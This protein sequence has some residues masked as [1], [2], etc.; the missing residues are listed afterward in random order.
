MRAITY[1]RHGGPD[2]M[3]V[4]E[5]PKPTPGPYEALIQV[6]AVSLNGFDPMML[7]GS[8]ELK[9]PMPMIPGGDLAGDIVALGERAHKPDPNGMPQL[10]LFDVARWKVGERVAPFPFVPGEGM[11]GETRRGACCEY[12]CFPVANLLP[13]PDELTYAQAAALPIAYGTA[14]RM[15]KTVGKVRARE[16]VLIL[17]ATGGVG[18]C[19][20]QLA[21]AAG[22]R[23]IAAGRGAERVAKLAKLGAD[24]VIDTNAQDLIQ[25]CHE[26]AGKPHMMSAKTGVDVVINYIGGDTWN[27]CL[28]VIKSNGRML[29]CGATAGHQATT[30]LRYLWTYEQKLMGSNG[31]FPPDQLELMG[32]VARGA[33]E[34]IIH[35][36]YALEDTPKAFKELMDRKA[37]GKIV[38]TP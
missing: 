38:I 3:S 16:T 18:T 17:G 29:T 36:E 2:V 19:A 5:L 34:P 28:K 33:L 13:V 21:K 37:F 22:A 12:I 25:T 10:A 15:L 11:T 14:Y 8:T 24:H 30:D 27:A 31:W 35:A 1:D 23:V 9:T 7:E 26:I 4:N 20:V 6:K 32:M